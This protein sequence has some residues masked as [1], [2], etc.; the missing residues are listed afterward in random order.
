MINIG[1]MNK[2]TLLIS[3]GTIV[4]SVCLI[5][6]ISCDGQTGQNINNAKNISPEQVLAELPVYPDALSQTPEE[7]IFRPFSTPLSPQVEGRPPPVEYE[8]ASA[9]YQV[10]VDANKLLDW[11][12]N[13]LTGKGY[14]KYT[15]MVYNNLNEVLLP[16]DNFDILTMGFYN[17]E[18]PEISIEVHITDLPD[19]QDFV[20]LVN[21]EITGAF[22]PPE[23][24]L[25]EDID[26]ITINYAGYN[27]NPLEQEV[28]TDP[29]DIRKIVSIINDLPLLPD[30][31][32]LPVEEIFSMSIYSASQKNIELCCD[33]STNDYPMI[34]ILDRIGLK[35]DNFRLLKAVNRLMN[36]D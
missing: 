22:D 20:I 30:A 4:L 32:I 25:P 1:Y 9:W 14:Q 19:T 7:S 35:D 24:P 13:K 5:L 18:L 10:E 2:G 17:P 23:P 33:M 36:I 29:G 16:D 21:H 15:E 27:G 31:P 3:L 6:N 12:R 8:T 11:Y 34:R 26:R 28:I